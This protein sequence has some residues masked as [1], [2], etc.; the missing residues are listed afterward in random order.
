M[1]DYLRG[2]DR[3]MGSANRESKERP[4]IPSVKDYEGKTTVENFVIADTLNRSRTLMK[5]L[6]QEMGCR[7]RSFRGSLENCDR[8]PD[9][10]LLRRV[11]CMRGELPDTHLT[12]TTGPTLARYCGALC[13]QRSNA[14][15][16][17]VIEGRDL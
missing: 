13:A 3:A 2:L 7:K 8:P 12:R 16:K 4:V 5:Y 11:R 1:D 10:I 14:T 9:R 6:L 17:D 15:P